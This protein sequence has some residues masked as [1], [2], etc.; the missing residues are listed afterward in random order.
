MKFQTPKLDQ[1]KNNLFYLL[2][3]QECY[4]QILLIAKSILERYENFNLIVKLQ[5]QV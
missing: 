4:Y 1:T 3:I 5:S 2:G